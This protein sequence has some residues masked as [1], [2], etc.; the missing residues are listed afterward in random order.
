MCSMCGGT[1]GGNGA[2]SVRARTRSWAGAPRG[3]PRPA[4]R[5]SQ[6]APSS[7]RRTCSNQPERPPAAAADTAARLS[8]PPPRIRRPPPRSPY[9]H[10]CAPY[11]TASRCLHTLP[12]RPGARWGSSV[13]AAWPVRYEDARRVKTERTHQ[14]TS[15]AGRVAASH[16]MEIG[17]PVSARST[18]R[19][20][21]CGGREGVTCMFGQS[22]RGESESQG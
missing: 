2:W 22:V 15:T 11:D 16:C 10:P 21:A 14:M 3:R 20:L 9:V 7:V 8:L 1:G 18:V 4:A 13:A 12:A 6:P 5:R 17:P 19:G